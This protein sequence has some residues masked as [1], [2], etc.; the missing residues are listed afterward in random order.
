MNRLS[1]AFLAHAR[2]TEDVRLPPPGA[3]G[4]LSAGAR[5]PPPGG[6][7]GGLGGSPRVP[8][9]AGAVFPPGAGFWG[10]PDRPPAGPRLGVVGAVRDVVSPAEQP[11]AL[12]ARF[13]DPAVAV[14]TLTITEKGYRRDRRGRLDLTDPLVAHDL[15]GGTPQS[16]VGR[17]AR[18]L[19]RRARGSGAPVTVLCCD[20]LTSNGRVLARLVA[21]FCAAL[22]GPE[23]ERL[24]GWIPANVTYPCTMVDRI[25]PATTPADR[26]FAQSLLGLVDEGLVV[27]EPFRPWVIEADFAA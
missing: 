1:N 22:P 25:V 10:G 16:A 18:G 24:A 6:G 19:Q 2:I 26:A 4:G 11:D 12:D 5:P 14:V 21:D 13:N 27:A 20:N 7:G 23:G 17:L 8:R 3:R 15:A 9:A